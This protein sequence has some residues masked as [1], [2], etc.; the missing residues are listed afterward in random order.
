MNKT[1]TKK[2]D[3]TQKQQL[4]I[5]ISFSV[6]LIIVGINILFALKIANATFAI[7]QQ[8]IN[9]QVKQQTAV[10]QTT[11]YENNPQMLDVI[12]AALPDQTEIVDVLTAI[13]NLGS[14]VGMKVNFNFA[15][16]DPTKE[17]NQLSVPFTLKSNT[18]IIKAI[19]FLRYF[20]KL[21]YLS[22]IT[23]LSIKSPQGIGGTIELSIIG[24]LYVQDPFNN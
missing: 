12:D 21:P 10:E 24:R 6:L 23:S 7:K 9:E 1:E 3:P 22:S 20:E 16:V 5:G 2:I 13:D 4:I 8:N 11:F 15:S 17:N 18:T 19:Q 14:L